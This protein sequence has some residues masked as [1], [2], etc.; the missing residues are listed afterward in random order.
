MLSLTFNQI[1]GCGK[2]MSDEQTALAKLSSI[3]ED[4]YKKYR[5]DGTMP[6]DRKQ[7]FSGYAD[8]LMTLGLL[9]QPQLEAL[10]KDANMKV[11][12]MTLKDRREVL[13]IKAN[14]SMFDSPAW[15][16]QGKTIRF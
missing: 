16:R 15:V 3:L 12:N 9:D 1:K 14:P 7:Y 8:A 4:V 5:D 2:T 10:V 13:D 6:N 11:F